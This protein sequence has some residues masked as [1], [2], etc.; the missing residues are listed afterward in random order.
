M[1]SP[2][3]PGFDFKN[4][5]LCDLMDDYAINGAVNSS[6]LYARIAFGL[7]CLSLM[8]LWYLLPKLFNTKKRVLMLMRLSGMVSMVTAL[9]LA[10]GIHDLITRISGILG[11]LALIILCMELLHE[12]FRK[13]AVFGALSLFMILINFY[14]YES[15]S[16]LYLLPLV[17]KFTFL[18]CITFFFLLNIS[19][20]Q[21][22]K[23][24]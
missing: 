12:N 6:S 14:I 7:L 24:P 23:N 18:S 3:Y 19:L 9:F 17:Q 22:L 13:L 1:V 4:N 11:I 5:Y 21:K 2:K 16:A 20:Y 8:L 10:S 15:G